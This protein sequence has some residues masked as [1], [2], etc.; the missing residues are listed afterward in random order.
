MPS[1]RYTALTASGERVV[2]MLAGASEQ[3]VLAELETRNLTP[4]SLTV[5]DERRP[6]LARRIASTRQLATAYT[7][8]A[9]L[10]RAGVPLMRGLRLLAGQKSAPRL[11]KVFGEIA[12]AVA[13][14]RDLADAMSDR[15]EVFPPIHVAMVRAGEKGG[16]LEA[17]LAR[18]GRFMTAQAELRA[19]VIGNLIYPCILVA[20]GSVVLALV[21]GVFIPMFKPLFEKMDLPASTRLVLATSDLV[22]RYGLLLLL[23]LGGIVALGVW[24]SRREDVREAIERARV[25]APILGPLTRAL[26]VSRFCRILGTMLAN[27]IPMLT[28]MQIARDAAGNRL[29]ERAIEEA[30]EAVRQ[31]QPLAPPLAQSGLFPEDIIEMIS[32]GESA[33]NLDEVLLGIAD[34]V[35][36]RVDRLL[37]T[38]VKLIEPVMLMA[39]AVVVGFV[40]MSLILPMTRISQNL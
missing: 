11:S 28:A 40:A 4:V 27:S 22:S 23:A 12:D 19:K 7:Q 26:A 38:A 29:L 36:G 15:P 5:E 30:T 3:A 1:F 20:V 35:D 39:L 33:N 34:T 13:E 17:V 9:D 14:G 6:V 32:V 18:L 25:R 31:G 2:G 10:L 24:L 16:F 8:L 37:S 21:F